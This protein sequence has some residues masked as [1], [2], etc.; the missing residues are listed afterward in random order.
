MMSSLFWGKPITT[1]G[2]NFNDAAAT[3]NWLIFS[4]L[5]LLENFKQHLGYSKQT[6]K[7]FDLADFYE[8]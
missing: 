3:E 1:L 4:R 7:Q 8:L 2:P 6:S 5:S